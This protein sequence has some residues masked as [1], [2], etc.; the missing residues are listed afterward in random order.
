MLT[1]PAV[2]IVCMKL[3][4]PEIFRAPPKSAP[5]PLLLAV[6][7]AI[8]ITL[9]PA[10]AAAQPTVGAQPPRRN[11]AEPAV[12]RTQNYEII[13]EDGPEMAAFFGQYMEQLFVAYTQRIG[14]VRSSARNIPRLKVHIASTPESFLKLVGQDMGNSAGIYDPSQQRIVARSDGPLDRTLRV[15]RHE[16]CHQF[17][18]QYIRRD[19]PI[20]IDEGL[21]VF[22]EEEIGRASWLETM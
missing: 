5:L 10:P 17:V 13:C 14:R 1:P 9:A 21:A 19:M 18:S 2:I 4:R 8:I 3:H 16:G 15:L 6:A 7:A 20:W 11:A 12:L 22:F